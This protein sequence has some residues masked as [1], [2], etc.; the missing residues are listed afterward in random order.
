MNFLSSNKFG[1]RILLFLAVCPVLSAADIQTNQ[2]VNV[3]ID[4]DRDI[5]PILATSCIRCHGPE[6]P[7]SRFH[8]DN[9]EAALKGGDENTNDIVPGDSSKSLLINY[10]ARQVPDMEMPPVGKGDSLTPQQITLL[11]AWID[12]GADWSTTNQLPQ[13][14]LTFAPMLRWIDVQGNQSKFRELEGVNPGFSGG[15]EDFSFTQQTS[16]D[17]KVSVTGHVIVPNQDIEVKL[18]VD[19][20]DRGFIHAGF[21]EWRTYYNN[22]GGYDPIVTP[23]EFSLN[24]DLHVD[25]G[26]AWIDFGLTLPHQ[27][28]VVLGYEYQFQNG[29]KSMLDWGSVL[30]NNPNFPSQF[31]KNIYPATQAVDEHTHIIKLDITHEFDEWHLADN[32]RVEFYSE[33]NLGVEFAGGLTPDLPI[34]QDTFINTQDKYQSTQGLNTLMLEKQI[35]D[36]WFLSGG[37]YYSKLEGSDFFNQTY[38]PGTVSPLSSQQITLNRESEIFSVASLFT[39]LTHLTFSLG[40]QNEWTTQNGFGN[41]VPDL[42]PFPTP[43]DEINEPV[44]SNSELFKSS[45]NASLRYTKIPFTVLFADGRFDQESVNQFQQQDP[46]GPINTETQTDATNYRYNFQSGF[47]TSPWRWCALN[48]QYQYQFSDSD[49][50]YPI[51]VVDG[52][53]GTGNGYPGFILNR[54]IKTDGFETKLDLRPA[55]WLKT[56]LS[57]KIAGTDYSSI[58]DP[59]FFPLGSTQLV[60]PGGSIM[61]G[62]FNTQT[63]GL[64]VTLTPI[65]RLF[66]Y[67]AFTYTHSRTVTASKDDPNGDNLSSIVPYSGDIYTLT[68]TATYALNPKT[69]LQAS[70]IFSYANYGQNNAV[71]GLPLGINF[72]RDEVLIGLTRQLTTRLSCA[73]HYQFSQ[74]NEPSSG[75]ANNF[76]AQGIFATLVYKWQ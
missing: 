27:P 7:R 54:K 74:Y 15:A 23:P 45:Q 9:R 32:A 39:P 12:Q 25:N 44:S 59:A 11:R 52:I 4:F 17:E 35:R 42:D 46:D 10:V 66:L 18:A 69:S 68:T 47:N 50:N 34:P 61:D 40:T 20:T 41:S 16:P 60:S 73:L 19:K 56:T 51:N 5:Q 55:N 57:Y 8:L 29:N 65:Q 75:N 71:E 48:A 62:T 6:K 49:Y 31:E 70:Y 38:T 37:F 1:T 36:W 22:V 13:P 63:Y 30:V 2:S 76:T 43:G 67:N 28:Q 3:K 24:R 14:A 58:T 33:N 64:S 26:H 53:S 72:T 21:D